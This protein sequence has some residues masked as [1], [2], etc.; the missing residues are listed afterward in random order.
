MIRTV[1]ASGDKSPH[2][3]T[4]PAGIL[5]HFPNYATQPPPT[6]RHHHVCDL[7]CCGLGQKISA[8]PP[9]MR[10]PPDHSSASPTLRFLVSWLPAQN[11]HVRRDVPPPYE[12]ERSAKAARTRRTPK[13]TPPEFSWHHVSLPKLRIPNRQPHSAPVMCVHLWLR[14]GCA[15]HRAEVSTLSH[16]SPGFYRYMGYRE[17]G[18]IPNW[19]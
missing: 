16:Q 7:W 2:S 13:R 5:Y 15:V 6:S 11:P 12:F 14:R 18:R 10:S 8:A 19:D 3:K 9:A 4:N 17:V 1:H